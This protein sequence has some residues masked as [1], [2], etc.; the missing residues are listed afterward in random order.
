MAGG[1]A[2]TFSTLIGGGIASNVNYAWIFWIFAIAS[3]VSSILAYFLIPPYL[4][5]TL[6]A[7]RNLST[8]QKLAKI[9]LIGALLIALFLILLVFALT[10]GNRLSWASARVLVPLLIALVT[11]LPAFLVWEDFGRTRRGLEAALP[12]SLWKLPNF[13]V[14]F[15]ATAASFYWYGTVY[16]TYTTLWSMAYQCEHCAE[17]CRR[18]LNVQQIPHGSKR[19]CFYPWA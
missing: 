7:Y 11:V 8:N 14:Y 3:L 9:D 6:Y 12:L 17:R 10:E 2:A 5:T 19:S 1:M 15:G 4:D 13:A 16:I 18:R